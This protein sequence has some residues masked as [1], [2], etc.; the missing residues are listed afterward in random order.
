ML[1][2][3]E[4]QSANLGKTKILICEPNL[5]QFCFMKQVLNVADGQYIYIGDLNQI[6]TVQ[7]LAFGQQSIVHMSS[8][9]LKVLN[10]GLYM[11]PFSPYRDV[12][13]KN[14]MYLAQAGI[15][16]HMKELAQVEK[17]GR[18]GSGQSSN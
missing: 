16:N 10:L 18:V 12:V 6:E 3:P 11:S 8:N 7:K 1:V 5:N 2:L 4:K 13:H 9:P 15:I 17:K 14:V